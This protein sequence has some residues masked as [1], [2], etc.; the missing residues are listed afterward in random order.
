M[1]FTQQ[2][3]FN[4]L[5]RTG[6][7]ISFVCLLA[8]A[9]SGLQSSRIPTE[10]EKIYASGKIVV[11][12]RNG[13][14]TYYEGPNGRTG[15]EYVL[16]Q[17]FADYL[18]VTLEIRET[19]DI[20][21]MLEKV[22][23]EEGHI[24]ASGLTVTERRKKRVRFSE[25]YM[26]ITQKLLY[27]SSTKK[28]Q[29]IEDLYGKK[30]LVIASSSHSERLKQLQREH[31]ELDWEERSDIEMLDL[32]E[33]VHTGEIDHTIV[34]SNAYD[35]NTSVYPR[36]LV[37]FDI[38]EPQNLAWAFS[39][40]KDTS[41]YNQAEKFFRSIKTEGSLD[42]A[43]ETFY[44]H[45]GEIDYSGALLFAKRLDT[46]LPKWRGQLQ[47][48]AEKH[49]LDWQ[50]LAALSY[51]ESHWN[52]KAKS[53]TGVR[54]FMMLTRDT[55]KYVGVKNR[56]D[57]KQSIEGGAEFFRYL[58]DRIDEE[59]AEPD[60]LWF[61][62]AAYNAGLGHVEDAR[63][64]AREQNRDPNKWA[65]VREVLPLLAKRAYY[66]HTKHGY[67]RGWEPVEYVKNIRNFQSI[68]A[69]NEVQKERT[70]LALNE[71][72]QVNFPEFSQ[73]MTEAVKI[74]STESL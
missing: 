30:I 59:I 73:V 6:K 9:A 13:P 63:I 44:G 35:I 14:T 71:E 42:D 26:Q 69:W 15:F 34:D 36:A 58:Y 23:Q 21:E 16:A 66:K 39:P 57:P 64:L 60:R 38:S 51:Q 17:Q 54:G 3:F 56:L 68:I 61:T 47:A 67:T 18:G 53:P 49:N 50:M 19:E 12:S 65:E 8:A 7:N 48:A 22:K 1:R 5:L 25:P 10:L 32:M 70:Q 55:A 27:R 37:G 46:R 74:I 40:S 29:S 62:M 41:L 2:Q 20:G 31:P 45:L 11:I 24:A 33:M 52:P 43:I 72:A 4:A 28:P